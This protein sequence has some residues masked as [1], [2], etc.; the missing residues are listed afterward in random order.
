MFLNSIRQKNEIIEAAALGSANHQK[1][2]AE[3]LCRLFCLTVSYIVFKYRM[4]MPRIR[5][6]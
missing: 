5:S 4:N 6:F 1:E 2:P 3:N